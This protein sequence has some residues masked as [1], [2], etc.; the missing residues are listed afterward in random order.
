MIVLS[1]V[2]SV[3]LGTIT[4]SNVGCILL[5]RIFVY[6]LLSKLG[7]ETGHQLVMFSLSQL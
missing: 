6:L 7:S 3:F 2:A 5:A 1:F 4:S